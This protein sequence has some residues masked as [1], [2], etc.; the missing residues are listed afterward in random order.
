MEIQKDYSIFPPA[1]KSKYRLFRKTAPK[2]VVRQPV[3]HPVEYR[4][5]TLA[6]KV[7]L[8]PNVFEFVFALADPSDVLGLPTGQHVAIRA[9]IDGKSVVR[10]YTPTSNDSDLGRLQLVIKVY[11][12][13]LLTNHLAAMEVGDQIDIRGPK[14][15]MK[16]HKDLCRNIGMIAGGTGI[17]P[18]YQLI[19]AICEDDSD[20]TN[21][22]LIYANQ[23]EDDILLRRELDGFAAKCPHKFRVWYVLSTAPEGWQY[24][25]G[26][27]TKELIEER[28]A[29]L[30]E[31]NKAMLCGPPGMINAMKNNLVALGYEKPSAVS[32]ATDQ[33][34]A[35]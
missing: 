10:S 3:L 22:S 27:A 20:N 30:S 13:G 33:I 4:K 17:T 2:K 34:F 35:F 14:G 16:Y 15:S 26:F 7:K 18:M 24:S 1:L 11:P 23:T 6:K 12:G 28:F 19:R 9:D 32:K 25:T 21:V 8:S 31:D 29:P 5:F